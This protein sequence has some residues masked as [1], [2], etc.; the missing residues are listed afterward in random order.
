MK[1]HFTVALATASLT[2]SLLAP[3]S[4]ETVTTTLDGRLLQFDQPAIMQDGRVMVPLRGIF[5]S[6]GAVVL[7]NSATQQIKA[8]KGSKLVQLSLGSRQAYVDGRMITLDVPANTLGGRTLVPLRFV[9]E[10]LGADVR[11][12][13]A[14][15]TVALTTVAGD[16]TSNIGTPAPVVNSAPLRISSVNHNGRKAKPG[17]RVLISVD[18]DPGSQASFD[19]VGV[20]NNIP[21]R[22]IRSGRYEGEWIVRSDISVQQIPIVAH[23]VKGNQT[24]TLES[25]RPLA[26]AGGN[27]ANNVASEL[28]PAPGTTVAQAR[29]TVHVNL[30]TNLQVGTARVFV[31][32]LEVTQQA[33]VVGSAVNYIPASDLTQ[34]QHRV[35]VQALDYSGRMLNKDWDFVVNSAYNT[36]LGNARSIGL[37]LSNLSNGSNVPGVFNVQGQTKPFSTVTVVAEA[38]RSLIP[39]VIG[40]QNRVASGSRQA[41]AYGRFDIPLDVTSLPMNT[42]VNLKI[43][44]TDSTGVAGT[45]TSISVNRR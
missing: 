32:G 25:R 13:P 18:G 36:N 38:Q 22:E 41:D 42:P 15:H 7:F 34:G 24:A 3:A 5:E 30:G 43:D 39:G 35:S 9:S 17:D 4:A 6:L 28:S 19:L 33:A 21:M 1:K 8:T 2:A 31:D 20:T 29:P 26:I 11:W 27:S 12:M 10:A 37:T 44:V 14:T 16:S 23:L 45:P 40:F